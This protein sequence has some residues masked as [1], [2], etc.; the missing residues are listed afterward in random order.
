MPQKFSRHSRRTHHKRFSAIISFFFCV[1]G[2]IVDRNEKLS[3][4][5]AERIFDARTN[6]KTPQLSVEKIIL[7]LNNLSSWKSWKENL[8]YSCTFPRCIFSLILKRKK[9]KRKSSSGRQ[10]RVGS[11]SRGPAERLQYLAGRNV[12]MCRL[13][14][15]IIAKAHCAERRR[16]R[17]W[18]RINR[19]WWAPQRV[20]PVQNLLD[21]HHFFQSFLPDF[22]PYRRASDR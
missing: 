18:D 15:T 20:A 17:L 3:K 11:P 1:V 10:R 21:S 13:Y 22:R 19:S 5:P 7:T 9:A 12:I 16:N 4:S 8:L 14:A 6:D 2:N